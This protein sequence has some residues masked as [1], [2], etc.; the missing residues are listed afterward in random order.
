MSVLNNAESVRMNEGTLMVPGVPASRSN[1]S[2]GLA[3]PHLEQ[4]VNCMEPNRNEF[5][6][7]LARPYQIIRKMR[8]DNAAFP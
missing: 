1:T 7:P 3:L 4:K 8:W 2:S 6:G 5:D